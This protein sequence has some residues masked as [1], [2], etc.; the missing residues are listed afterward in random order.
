MSLIG[1]RKFI[2]KFG[3]LLITSYICI[4]ESY[5]NMESYDNKYQISNLGNVKSLKRQEKIMKSSLDGC[6]YLR[7][8]LYKNGKYYTHNIHRLIA[9]HFIPNPE[10]HSSVNHING[11]KLDNR[12]ENLEWISHKDNI[13]HAWNTGLCKP[14]TGK[15]NGMT[16][17]TESDILAI[18]SDN[19]PASQIAKDYNIHECSVSGIKTRRTWKHI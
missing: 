18:R 17:L 19:R 14:L 7:V 15:N 1:Q 3:N 13:L 12:V 2:N 11:N 9:I 16:K 5:I 8:S 10:N 4:M 6:G